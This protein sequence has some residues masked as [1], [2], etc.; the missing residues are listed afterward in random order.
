MG[1]NQIVIMTEFEVI[2]DSGAGPLRQKIRWLRKQVLKGMLLP[3]QRCRRCTC[4]RNGMSIIS[5][6]AAVGNVY[7]RTIH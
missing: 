3:M 1:V 7:Q 5:F 6:D 4:R 2:P